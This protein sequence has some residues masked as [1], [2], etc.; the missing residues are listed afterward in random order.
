[1]PFWMRSCFEHIP[2]RPPNPFVGLVN[3]R[4]SSQS[5]AAF[6]PSSL[7][8]EVLSHWGIGLSLFYREPQQSVP[9]RHSFGIFFEKN[10]SFA[11]RSLRKT[12]SSMLTSCNLLCTNRFVFSF[13]QAANI[14]S[15]SSCRACS[16]GFNWRADV[17]SLVQTSPN[18]QAFSFRFKLRDIFFFRK[19]IAANQNCLFI[20]LTEATGC[21]R[22]IGFTNLLYED[23]FTI[24]ERTDLAVFRRLTIADYKPVRVHGFLERRSVSLIP[25][26]GLTRFKLVKSKLFCETVLF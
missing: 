21:K 24:D 1:M 10:F 2:N 6:R 19:I 26:D 13:F 9:I 7:R 12:S 16:A 25:W 15:F 23:R 5:M 18:S 4:L 22:F 3:L 20:G 17:Q 8:Q 11:P 14:W